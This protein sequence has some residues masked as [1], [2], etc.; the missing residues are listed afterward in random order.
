MRLLLRRDNESMGM[1]P[2]REKLGGEAGDRRDV[3][4]VDSSKKLGS[5]ACPSSLG[6][7]KIDSY[8]TFLISTAESALA[9]IAALVPVG[10][11]PEPS[12]K[13]PEPQ[14]SCRA[15]GTYLHGRRIH[16]PLREFPE[17]VVS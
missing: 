7:P 11:A 10:S 2:A 6:F 15:C 3:R 5:S 1:F 13:T 14:L 8:S 16:Y 12:Q 9:G 17:P 4:Q